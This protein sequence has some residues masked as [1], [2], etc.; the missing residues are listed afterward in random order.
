VERI[1]SRF[2][3]VDLLTNDPSV[4][5]TESGGVFLELNTT[6]SIHH[7][8]IGTRSESVA[9]RVLQYLLDKDND[10]QRRNRLLA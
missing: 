2:A 9:V 5:L 8:A 6:P 4:P 3:G 7:H 1:G 10:E